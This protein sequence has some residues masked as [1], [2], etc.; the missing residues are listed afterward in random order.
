MLPITKLS[1][2]TAKLSVTKTNMTYVMFL[3]SSTAKLSVT[4]TGQTGLM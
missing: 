1:S 4:K 2:S 3:K